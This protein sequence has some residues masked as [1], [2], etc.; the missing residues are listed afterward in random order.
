[1]NNVYW[2]CTVAKASS[3]KNVSHLQFPNESVVRFLSHF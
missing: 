3:G 1:M 2:K